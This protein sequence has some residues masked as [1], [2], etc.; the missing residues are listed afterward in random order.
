MHT[1]KEAHLPQEEGAFTLSQYAFHPLQL[2]LK[3]S[4]ELGHLCRVF[5]LVPVEHAACIS[6]FKGNKHEH[7]PPIIHYPAS[8]KPFKF[9]QG[10]H[11]HNA[12]LRCRDV[13]V[14]DPTSRHE[15]KTCSPHIMTILQVLNYSKC[16]LAEAR[17]CGQQRDLR[18][19]RLHLLC[20]R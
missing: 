2:P 8:N 18:E 1:T 6:Q 7:A 3:F 20:A 11:L 14:S 13:A 12:P 5:R 15:L 10:T 17:V 9:W 16:F 19:S 4:L